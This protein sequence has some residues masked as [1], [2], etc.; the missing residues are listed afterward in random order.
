MNGNPIGSQL[1]YSLPAP[2]VSGFQLGES[3]L[4]AIKAS[5]SLEGYVQA[6][7]G[8]NRL[9][10]WVLGLG[11]A[12]LSPVFGKIW[13][14]SWLIYGPILGPFL[15]E[16]LTI[17]GFKIAPEVHLLMKILITSTYNYV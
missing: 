12:G 8:L 2:F 7:L 3:L 9:P 16:N 4:V 11:W 1:Q 17:C 5:H 10:A 14:L 15:R 6:E 13:T